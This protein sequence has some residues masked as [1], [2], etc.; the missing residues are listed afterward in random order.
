MCGI[1][2]YFGK[3]GPAH[4]KMF[5][6]LWQM[7][8]LRGKDSCGVAVISDSNV[9][10]LK[11]TVLP[12]EMMLYYENYKK[13]F[14][15]KNNQKLLG[16]IGHNRFS[17][18][19]AV[20]DKNAHPFQH[21]YITLVHNGTAFVWRLDRHLDF[22]TDSEAITHSISKIGI[23]ETWPLI[24]GAMTL[25][26]WDNKNKTYNMVTNGKRPMN[27]TY[28]KDKSGIFLASEEW[29]IFS[30][31]ARNNMQLY[32]EP[33]VKWWYLKPNTLYSFKTEN[34]QITYDITE[35][36]E[37]KPPVYNSQRNSMAGTHS[38]WNPRTRSWDHGEPEDKFDFTKIEDN[39]NVVPFGPVGG[40]TKAKQ[41]VI[42]IDPRAKKISRKDYEAYYSSCI[43]CGKGVNNQYKESVI[44]D[45]DECHA[46]CK[47]CVEI[48][49]SDNLVIN[50][51]TATIH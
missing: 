26:Y 32:S 21:G 25:V 12:H 20:T 34:N 22:D 37:W 14:R 4:I 51:E 43:G 47:D 10:V 15:K 45:Y 28:T 27:F 8:V 31:A 36:K 41:S 5:E 38:V 49:E 17:T 23:E 2:G 30:A 1:V 48:G 18:R 29:M 16:L 19:G 9:E 3:V 24:D 7:D 42:K 13:V 50:K 33:D 35:L 6:D 11:D 46:L 39:N 40:G 44:V